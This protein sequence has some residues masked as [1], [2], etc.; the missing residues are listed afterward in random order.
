MPPYYRGSPSFVFFKDSEASGYKLIAVFG[1]V[2][3]SQ[4]DSISAQL[5]ASYGP[6]KVWE[7][8][9]I[10]GHLHCEWRTNSCTIKLTDAGG[11]LAKL[12]YTENSSYA[13]FRESARKSEAEHDRKLQLA[14]AAQEQT[15]EQDDKHR[16]EL[17]R[18]AV[19]D[20]KKRAGALIAEWIDS[21]Q[22]KVLSIRQPIR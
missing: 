3:L 15:R 6:A 7:P 11:P 14:A 12:E 5:R 8:L 13:K 17:W 1:N 20:R 4:S 19:E 21:V 10:H 16:Q 9:D 2:E 22:E 18:E